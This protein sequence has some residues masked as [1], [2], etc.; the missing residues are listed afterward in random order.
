MYTVMSCMWFHYQSKVYGILDDI[1]TT[2]RVFEFH[3][4]AKA[5]SELERNEKL[6]IVCPCLSCLTSHVILDVITQ[7]PVYMKI[8][9]CSKWKM[10]SLAFPL[11][12]KLSAEDRS[13]CEVTIIHVKIRLAHRY[14]AKSS[15]FETPL[16][17]AIFNLSYIA[18]SPMT[19]I[20]YL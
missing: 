7:W 9:C 14:Y 20:E 1:Q 8:R 15:L 2:V 10:Y 19:H 17:I 6:Q 3:C 11:W 13:L 12:N 16:Y 5:R 18:I 4:F